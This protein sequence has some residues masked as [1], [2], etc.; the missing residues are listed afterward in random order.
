MQHVTSLSYQFLLYKGGNKNSLLKNSFALSPFLT[1]LLYKLYKTLS[2]V[3][4]LYEIFFTIF[5]IRV[6]P[7]AKS[8]LFSS[9]LNFVSKFVI[10]FLRPTCF[11]I[12]VHFCWSPHF[13][14]WVSTF[15]LSLFCS[16]LH[17][18][19]E[20]WPGPCSMYYWCRGQ[21]FF[22]VKCHIRIKSWTFLFMVKLWSKRRQ[23]C[24]FRW[25]GWKWKLFLKLLEKT[26]AG[27]RFQVFSFYPQIC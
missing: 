14:Q 7:F 3:Y 4:L 1:K 23:V 9:T 24:S 5:L 6:S 15:Y 16:S 22:F 13:L 12:L 17:N 8:A 27:A 21:R 11:F 10:L 18:P 2:F 19:W 20:L 25:I 26:A